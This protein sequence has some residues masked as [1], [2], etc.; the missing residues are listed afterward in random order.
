MEKKFGT[1]IKNIESRVKTTNSGMSFIQ[2][3]NW[4]GLKN[5]GY[6]LQKKALSER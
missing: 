6:K 5:L 3:W 1:I 4:F 2:K